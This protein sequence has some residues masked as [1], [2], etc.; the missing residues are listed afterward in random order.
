MDAMN[1]LKLIPPLLLAA[2]LA[3][4]GCSTPAARPAPLVSSAAGKDLRTVGL[5]F[6]AACPDLLVEQTAM[7][8]T[9]ASAQ[10]ALAGLGVL[11]LFRSARSR[12]P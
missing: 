5:G 9:K 1:L 2:A 12:Y 4:T 10:G 11:S 7:S 8:K 3:L 6:S